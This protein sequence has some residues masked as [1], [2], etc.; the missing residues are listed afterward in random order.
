MVRSKKDGLP[1][2]TARPL[3]TCI[4]RELLWRV[5]HAAAIRWNRRLRGL[6]ISGPS[7]L[8]RR[9]GRG[10]R[11]RARLGLHFRSRFA[12]RSGLAGLDAD[13]GS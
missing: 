10:R 11:G 12:R 13:R 1:Q 9:R 8:R 5:R 3:P 7:R 6:R 4:R 2:G